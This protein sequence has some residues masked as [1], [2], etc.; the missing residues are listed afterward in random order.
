MGWA[1]TGR[2]CPNH[3]MMKNTK[4]IH[5]GSVVARVNKDRASRRTS[6]RRSEKYATGAQLRGRNNFVTGTWNV[7]TL[8]ATGK[9]QQLTYEMS[10]Y[11]WQI[12]GLCETR[13]KNFGETMTEE[14][15]KIYFSGKENK[16]EHGVGFLVHKDIVSSVMGCRP[17]SHRIITI[18][19]RATP[20]NITIVQVYAPTSDYSDEDIENFMNKYKRSSTK[21]PRKTF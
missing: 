4:S 6:G 8:H 2:I 19:L 9:E 17:V 5:T 16:H 11:N 14:G 13:W 20:F 15:H 21:H 1:P 18:R 12:I 3:T 7:R 10:R